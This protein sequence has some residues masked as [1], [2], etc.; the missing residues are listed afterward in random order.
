MADAPKPAPKP[1][2]KY[3]P[4]KELEQ[5]AAVQKFQGRPKRQPVEQA[6]YFYNVKGTH[7]AFFLSSVGMLVAFLMMF[8]KDDARPWKPYQKQFAQMDFEKLWYDMNGLQKDVLAMGKEIEDIERNID[9]ILSKFPTDPKKGVEFDVDEFKDQGLL[10]VPGLE[11]APFNG[12]A[13]VFVNEKKKLEVAEKEEVRG[14]LYRRL[15]LMNFAKD[16]LG[17]VRFRYE[18]AKHHFEDAVKTGSDR[19][20]FYEGHYETEKKEWDRVNKEVEERKADADEVQKRSDFYEEFAA[21]LEKKTQGKENGKNWKVKRALEDLRA[22]RTAKLKE[23]EDKKTRFA[24]EKP[25]FANTVRNAP[26]SD[27]FAPTLKVRNHILPDIKDQL[28]FATVT[29]VDRCDTCHVAIDNPTYEVRINPD[30]KEGDENKYTFKEPFLQQFV[31]HARGTVEKKD[32]V[33]C[34]EEGRK[35]KEIKEPLTPHKSWESG[36]VVKFTK[37][38]MAHPRLDLFAA[39]SSKHPIAKFGCTVCHEGD[40]RDTDFTR[41]V[42]TPNSEHQGK[43]W[44]NRH[45]TPYGEERYNWNYRELWDLPMFPTKY[46][47]ASCRRCHTDAV[48]LDGAPKYVQGM[49]LVE[50]IGCYGCHRMDTYQIL[51]KDVNNVAVDPNRKNR[52]PGP[53]LLR[54]A[55]KVSEDWAAKWVLAPRDFR[56]T[57]RMPHFFG[58]SNTR[59]KVNQN[60]YP[61]VEVNGVKRSPVDDTIVASL[62]KYVWSLSDKEADPA[63]PALKGDA[64]KGEIIVKQVGCTA[65]HKLVE[66]PL[67]V[68][69][70]QSPEKP[71]TRSRYLEDF[72]PT[73]FGVGSKMNKAWLFAWVRNPKKHFKDSSMPNLRL[74]EQEATDVVEYLM[75]LKKPEW[76]KLAA[77]Q[78]NGKIVDDLIVEILKKV[79]SDYDA[80]QTLAGKNPLPEYKEMASAD[81]KVKWLGRKMVKNFGCYSCHQLKDDPDSG[82]KWQDEEG[83]GVELS[84]SQPWGSKHHDKLDFGFAA[85]DGVNHHGVEAVDAFDRP[86]KA[87]VAESRAAWLENKL[88][89]PRIYDAGKMASKPWDELLRMP[90]FGLN[91]MEI[92]LVATFVQSFT[93][94]A[95]TGLVEN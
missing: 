58:Q 79:M 82:M 71:A 50:R 56:S 47:Q 52:R 25:S 57:T 70:D 9:L 14:D 19:R 46:V 18:E 39:D 26:M 13:H 17:A 87:H 67:S 1:E 38:F 29:K 23:L 35:T 34:D 53:P 48:D 37:T 15:Q 60:D 80:A 16:E 7:I 95:V 21:A 84:G 68:F 77:P 90:N 65:C 78:A 33:V 74:S 81:G 55:T 51:P 10:P 6:E 85:D 5:K 42:H 86:V 62:V 63:P 41:V 69:Q 61:V 3:E 22:D 11:K 2:A 92:E 31:A 64:I 45:G 75:T 44:R 4:P 66:T 73:L 83:I 12:K 93:D 43:E 8:H 28:N 27:F 89:N 59:A 76:E 88:E 54:I 94:H 40:G 36:D 72:A 32:C 91:K 24:K 20:S 49:K 30:L